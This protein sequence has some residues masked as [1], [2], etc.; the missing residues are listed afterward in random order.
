MQDIGSSLATLLGGNYVNRFNLNGRSYQVIPQV[1]REFRLTPDWLKRYQVRTSVRHMVPLSSVVDVRQ[2]RAAECADQLPAAQF[3]DA[4]G[5][6]VPG[7]TVGEAID[8]LKAK[9]KELFPEGFTYDFQG[10][11]RQ[12][13]QEGNTL[14]VTFVFALII[15][16]LVLAAQFESF[17]DPLIILI[18]LPT[19]MFGA[20]LPLNISGSASINIYTQIGLVTLIGLIS[21]H[22]ILMVEFAN[23]LQ[24]DEGARAPRGDRGGGRRPAAADPDD[25]GGHGHRHGPADLRHR[26][27]RRSRFAI[28][29]VIAVG[30]DHRH[31]VH[32]VHHA[33][34][35]HLHRRRASPR[36]RG[37][38]TCARQSRRQD[39][40]SRAASRRRGRRAP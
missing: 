39:R 38:R 22:G 14:V 24:D 31:D 10:E 20:L 17:R 29:V 5:R 27:R 32:A 7:R 19:S 4:A 21:K 1:P 2:T 23:Q 36:R 40:R 16:Y 15:I 37:R 25:D 34:G 8:F 28:G 18:A 9:A 12:Y 30:H 33:R 6:A 13:V 26:R 11:S 3:R 35:L